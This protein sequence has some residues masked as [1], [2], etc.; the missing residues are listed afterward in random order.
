MRFDECPDY[1]GE[2]K[3]VEVFGEKYTASFPRNHTNVQ[4]IV[5]DC[6]DLNAGDSYANISRYYLKI[7]VLEKGRTQWKNVYCGL[8]KDYHGDLDI[9][10]TLPLLF[11]LEDLS[12]R[13]RWL[14]QNKIKKL[15]GTI[16]ESQKQLDELLAQ[17]D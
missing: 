4:A 2:S 9:S 5:L 7:F 17:K 15:R 1:V 8:K 12:F 16:S 10:G 3:R 11:S 6:K 13:R 14:R